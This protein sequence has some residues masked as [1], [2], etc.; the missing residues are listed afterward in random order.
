MSS[1]MKKPD[2][3]GESHPSR[4]QTRQGFSRMLEMS[5]ATPPADPS[6]HGSDDLGTA[7]IGRSASTREGAFLV[8]DV[9]GTHARLGL[10]APNAK[11]G[12]VEI[13][14]YRTYRCGDHPHMED[15]ARCFCEEFGVQPRVL[16]LACAGYMHAGSVINKNLPWPVMP[17]MMKE[18]LELDNVTSLNDLEA[19]AYAVGHIDSHGA[20]TLKAPMMSVR[21]A[22]PIVILGPGTGLGAAVWFPGQPP[23]V[24]A[25]EAGQIQLAARV[26][27]EQQ[28]LAQLA[29]AD[30]HVS[31]EA[32]LS[33][34]GLH[35]LYVALCAIR[36]RYP[37]L[38][39]PVAVTSAALAGG[40]DVA[41]EALTLFCGWLG[42]FAA[43]LA[44]LYGT[45]GGICLVGGLL[46]QMI[47]FL[48]E[49][50][51]IDRFLDKG[52]MRPFLQKIPIRVME[53]GRH[54]VIGAASW[55]LGKHVNADG[56]KL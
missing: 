6:E 22:G 12:E 29:Q 8:A 20:P 34:P 37:S 42:S 14:A 11:E 45:T 5:V 55:Y 52:V 40:D 30:S 13:L 44:M 25:T 1:P 54:G 43:D 38:D 10:V 28:V 48:Q 21:E 36:D 46:S 32:V 47:G 16:V 3:S 19:L 51:F 41:R 2:Q 4:V 53:R 24:M 17:R 15:I 9:G 39:E 7:L 26:G 35:R 18:A 49:S 56:F 50:P 31:Y 33:G 23:R 27:I